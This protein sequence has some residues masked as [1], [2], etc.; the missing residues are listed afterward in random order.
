MRGQETAW[1]DSLESLWGKLGVTAVVS[2][3]K[4]AGGKQMTR[5]ESRV[6][7]ARERSLSRTLTRALRHEPWTYGIELDGSGWGDAVAFAEHL[8]GMSKV[9]AWVT[10]E[11]LADFFSR[12]S[13]QRFE[14][15]EG[16]MRA[17]YG[18]SIGG[19]QAG[20][21]RRPPET[22]YHGTDQR[23]VSE[24]LSVGLHTMGRS[25]VHLTSDVDYAIRVAGN[26]SRNW[27]VIA[28]N[29][30]EEAARGHVFYQANRHVW[31]TG[32]MPANLLD[33]VYV[34][35]ACVPGGNVGRE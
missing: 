4:V 2:A 12:D 33:V 15:D 17:L 24:I 18:H 29:A 35:S 32:E 30:E 23:T 27:V 34:A 20:V 25:W 14:Y 11:G 9:W 7:R 3:R 22:L 28:V 5:R 16:R 26:K 6:Q 8:R 1:S 31:Q 21:A 13:E 19:I 10:D